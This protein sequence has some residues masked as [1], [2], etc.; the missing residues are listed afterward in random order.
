MLHTPTNTYSVTS[1]GM[2]FVCYYFF[3]C[4]T[5]GMWIS[6]GLF[7]PNLCLGALWGRLIG[8]FLHTFFPQVAWLDTGV[9][10]LL[11]AAAQLSGLV[12]MTFSLSMILMEATREFFSFEINSV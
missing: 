11:G 9:Y 8:I 10:A 7:V 5:Y 6:S 2:F 3:T 4:A 1:L 12:R